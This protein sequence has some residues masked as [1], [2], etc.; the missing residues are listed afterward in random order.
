MKAEKISFLFTDVI[1]ILGWTS[2]ALS[3]INF[4]FIKKWNTDI[5]HS[6]NFIFFLDRIKLEKT[7]D[8]KKDNQWYKFMPTGNWI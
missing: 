4:G 5:L 6:V 7:L 2:I 8:K 3:W 1:I